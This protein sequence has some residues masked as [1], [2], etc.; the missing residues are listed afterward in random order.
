[1]PASDVYSVTEV[2]ADGLDPATSPR[3]DFLLLRLDRN[4]GDRFPRVRRS[5]Q[6]AR[7]RRTMTA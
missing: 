1:M 3:R 5:G 2:V 7:T 4:A 6:G